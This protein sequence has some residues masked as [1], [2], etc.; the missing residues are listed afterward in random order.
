MGKILVTGASG[1]L[2]RRTLVHLL[3][4]R[5]ATDLVGLAR[6]PAKAADLAA[7]GIEVRRGDYLDP[8]SLTRA[9]DD[10]HKVML[11]AT[12]AFTDRRTA[13]RNV[14]DAAVRSGVEHLVFMPIIR[15]QNSAFSMKEIT[16]E[17]LFTEER[18]LTSGLA[19]TLARH[20]AFLD[21][22]IAYT[23]MS[24]E[25][26]GVHVPAGDGKFTAA[27]RD[28]LAE[29]HAAILTGTGH[30]NRTYS[31]TGGPA[32][33]FSDIA[34]ILSEISGSP[35]SYNPLTDEEYLELNR[36]AGL[37]DFVVEFVLGWLHGMNAGEWAEQTGDLEMLLGRKPTSPTD[38]FRDQISNGD[39]L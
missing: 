9:F 35:V 24:P 11:T 32:V 36:S 15:K 23:G 27:A 25:R 33:S 10:V 19:W 20:P 37:P 26:P 34:A 14:I 3:K 39:T 1:N 8:D 31:L 12:H 5:P 13:H 29:A 17:D 21:T 6:D 22:I 7:Q 2:G 30:E 4:R 28:D 18:L 16:E 38:F